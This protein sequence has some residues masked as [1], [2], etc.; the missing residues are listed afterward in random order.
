MA[1]Q[2]RTRTQ[3]RRLDWRIWLGLVLTTVYLAY[4]LYHIT[5]DV[6]WSD[7]SRQSLESQGSF[8]EGA[9][10]PLAFLWLVVGY[11]LQHKALQEK[12][13]GIPRLRNACPVARLSE[14]IGGQKNGQGVN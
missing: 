8:L 7:F 3:R 5:V 2:L 1:E 6:G 11:F 4:G 14:L 13:W 9:F 12:V 10:A